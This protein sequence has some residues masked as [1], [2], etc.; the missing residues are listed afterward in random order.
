MNKIE[1]E[2]VTPDR[3]FFSGEV[4]EVTVPGL[5]GYMGIL[6]GHAPLLSELKSG[7]ISYKRNGLQTRLYSGGGFVEVLPGRVSV[8]TEDAAPPD[9]ID[10]VQAR[11][12]QEQ[13]EEM[14]RS[15]DTEDYG[16]AMRRW[17]EAVARL[18][19]AEE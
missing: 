10:V 17:E 9:E 2:I 4:D 14:L 13:A 15:H 7:V 16:F 12:N 3:L 19:A 6:P 8:L 5:D 1:L 18:E 11:A